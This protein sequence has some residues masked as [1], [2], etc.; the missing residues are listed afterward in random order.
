MVVTRSGKRSV[1]CAPISPPIR[2]EEP[3]CKKLQQELIPAQTSGQDMT[4]R[5]VEGGIA[6]DIS[7]DTILQRTGIVAGPLDVLPDVIIEQCEIEIGKYQERL[8][9]NDSD[10]EDCVATQ[11]TCAMRILR[12]EVYGQH[13]S[14]ARLL[15]VI[16]RQMLPALNNALEIL[17]AKIAKPTGCAESQQ[18]LADT[19][20]IIKETKGV[21]MYFQNLMDDT[22]EHYKIRRT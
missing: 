10:E 20:P 17:S 16:Q 18:G 7:N 2:L 11:V 21:I 8:W 15:P 22:A 6:H 13:G 4:P 9:K 12:A 19:D 1:G 14:A 3:D 5:P